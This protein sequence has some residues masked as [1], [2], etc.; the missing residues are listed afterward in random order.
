MCVHR[1]STF[2]QILSI[3]EVKDKG[4]TGKK[5]NEKVLLKDMEVCSIVLLLNN[6]IY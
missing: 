2:L 4:L 5:E 3:T 1:M 6:F